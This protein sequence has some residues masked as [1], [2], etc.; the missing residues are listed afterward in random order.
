MKKNQYAIISI[1]DDEMK[2]KST[3]SLSKPKRG[4]QINLCIELLKKFRV[5]S[6]PGLT[7]HKLSGYVST[8]KKERRLDN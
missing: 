2:I 1:D 5:P 3:A 8:L 6:K 4:N 7:E